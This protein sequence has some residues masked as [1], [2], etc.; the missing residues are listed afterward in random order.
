[1]ALARTGRSLKIF[2]DFFTRYNASTSPLCC[3]TPI[4]NGEPKVDIAQGHEPFY[5]SGFED[6]PKLGRG[7]MED[8]LESYTT[9]DGFNMPELLNDDYFNAIKLLFNSKYYVSFI[10]TVSYIEFGDI[11]GGFVQWLNKYALIEKLGITELQL[12]EHRNSVLHMSNL[13]SRKVLAGKEKRISFC[14]AQSGYVSSQD[15]D[16]QYFNL[17]DL[18]DEIAQALSRWIQTYED[19]RDKI[20]IFVERYDRV[21]SDSRQAIKH[22]EQKP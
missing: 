12:W 2:E 4:V 7:K 1:M 17:K 9:S 18:I 20:L 3:I 14:V 10:D 11:S 15:L 22:V 21:I 8:Y 5:V 6:H 16:T 19:D 13:D